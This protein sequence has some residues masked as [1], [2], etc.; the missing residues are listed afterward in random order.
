M[1]RNLDK[2]NKRYKKELDKEELEQKYIKNL[3]TIKSAVIHASVGIIELFRCEIDG[4]FKYGK[5]SKEGFKDHVESKFDTFQFV[6]QIYEFLVHFDSYEKAMQLN[7]AA[8][9]ENKNKRVKKSTQ[10]L[11]DKDEEK[12]HNAQPAYAYLSNSN[13][14]NVLARF[15]SPFFPNLLCGTST[16]EEG[17]N[18]HMHCNKVYHF[19]A[20]HTMGSDEQRIGRVDRLHGK[21]HRELE[22]DE[23]KK[24]NIHYPYLKSTFDE[25]NLRSMLCKK[26]YTEKDID[27]CKRA[28]NF[29]KG[30]DR[31]VI[32]DKEISSL[33]HNSNK[34][35]KYD[36]E[37]YGWEMLK[38]D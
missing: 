17:L 37:P 26:R 6:G 25:E 10:K 21:M 11:A 23:T 4:G 8:Q 14:E 31:E 1:I 35:S 24:L 13:N 33:L 7:K 2:L 5:I 3:K 29:D 38:D 12:F 34:N 19:S 18:L 28:S 15:N 20:A 16:L 36:A 30:E 32:C 9:D 22:E 27:V